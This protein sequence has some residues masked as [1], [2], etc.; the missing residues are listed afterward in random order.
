MNILLKLDLL[1]LQLARRLLTCALTASGSL[2]ITALVSR[3]SLSST[4]LVEELA[5]DLVP[6]F[7]SACL[8]ITARS[9]SLGSLCTHPPRSLPRW[10]SHTTVSCPPTLSSSTLMSLSFSTMR[11]SILFHCSR[12]Y[13]SSRLEHENIVQYFGTDKVLNSFL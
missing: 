8:L 7:W 1:L 10:L 12:R 9:P 13:L 11:P 6:S 4:L 2:P 3:A 5:L